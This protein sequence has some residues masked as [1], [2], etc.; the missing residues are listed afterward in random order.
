[1]AHT[2]KWARYKKVALKDNTK[3]RGVVQNVAEPYEADD[4]SVL[5]MVRWDG[6]GQDFGYLEEML[7]DADTVKE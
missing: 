5:Y 6:F 7:I 4:G 2:I 1:M 3:F